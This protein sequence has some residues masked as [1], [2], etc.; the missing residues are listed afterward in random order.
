MLQPGRFS[1]R[2]LSAV[3]VAVLS[4]GVAVTVARTGRRVRTTPVA[5]P[6][7]AE[8]SP[9]PLSDEARAAAYRLVPALQPGGLPAG[10]VLERATTVL[11]AGSVPECEQLELDYG[12]PGTDHDYLY[13]FQ[14]PSGCV[15]SAAPP[16]ST[17]FRAGLATG[18]QVVDPAKGTVRIRVVVGPAVLE[19]QSDLAPDVLAR[20]LDRLAPFDPQR[21]PGPLPA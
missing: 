6:L 2:W 14:L 8:P 10:W 21:P 13:L 4:V 7:P 18:A 17:P 19:A 12:L 5:A 15:D 9:P 11:V 16:G 3:I 1:T 20:A